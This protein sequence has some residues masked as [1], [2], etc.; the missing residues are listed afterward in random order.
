MANEQQSK[1][2]SGPGG[3][4][5]VTN[6]KQMDIMLQPL[7]DAALKDIDLG[8]VEH[9]IDIGCGT[10]TTTL[11]IAAQLP[12]SAKVTGADLS[13]PMIE[14]AN[15]RLAASDIGNAEFIN[16]DLQEDALEPDLYDAAFSR[17]GVMFFDQSVKGF[18]N[19]RAAMKPGAPMAFVCWQAPAD[20]LWHSAAMAV[21][22]EFMEMP[23]APDPRAPGPFAFA[24]PGYLTSILDDAGFS[25]ASL[26]SHEQEVELFSGQD[27]R[28]ASENFARINPVIGAFVSEADADTTAAFF[29]AL[30]ETLAPYHRDNALHFPSATWLVSAAA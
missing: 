29:D 26:T 7:G 1:F 6:Q 18:A 8:G 19:I 28:S 20:N 25:N 9:I 12:D 15:Q 27:V 11:D 23:A 21:A 5:W 17:F 16:A 14:Y 10:G 4:S 2:W 30:A 3:Q 24:E 13:V 22:K